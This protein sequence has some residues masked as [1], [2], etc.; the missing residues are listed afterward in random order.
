[1]RG[2]A[3]KRSEQRQ[4]ALDFGAPSRPAPQAPSITPSSITLAQPPVAR[5]SPPPADTLAIDET[6]LARRIE[7]TLGRAVRVE[8]TANRR[9]MISTRRREGTLEV[10]LHRMFLTAEPLVLEAIGRYLDNGDR[11]SSR[12]ISA[13]IEANR[14]LARPPMQRE[15][16][17]AGRVHD[18]ASIL[19][20]VIEQLACEVDPRLGITWGRAGTARGRRRRSIRLGTYTHD[21]RLIRVHPVLD[22]EWVP[23]M[24]VRYIVFHEL[25]HHLE[26]AVE[27]EGRT[28]FHTAAFRARE[29]AWP[30]YDRA[31]M[32]ERVN[33][34][35]LLG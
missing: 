4:L 13:Y 22:A 3:A 23:H 18:L 24:F 28:I 29:R 19:R 34:P 11:K 35:R 7:R 10:R 5:V 12:L 27:H 30:D 25:L 9:T 1:M 16:R 20:G 8:L 2:V 6:V 15:L 21:D 32:W 17:P 33:L 31:L 14:E 26:P